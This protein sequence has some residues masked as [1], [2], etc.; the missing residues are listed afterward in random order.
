MSKDKI[1]GTKTKAKELV[2]FILTSLEAD[3]A[4]DV[5]IIDLEGKADF[6]FYVIIASGR[7][8]RHISSMADS[9][10]DKLK[11]S[12]LSHIGIEGKAVGDWVLID[13]GDVIVHLFRPEIR[14]N[15]EI[16]KIWN[17]YTPVT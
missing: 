7:S 4:E 14:E 11:A 8:S 1:L 2:D 10:A 6:A 3:K 16:E 17:L 13:A 15:Y 12:G 5:V 9:A